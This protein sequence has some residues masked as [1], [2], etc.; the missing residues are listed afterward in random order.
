MFG[1]NAFYDYT[2]E[3]SHQR[4]GLGGEVFNQYGTF[5]VNG[6][7]GISDKRTLSDS[8]TEKAVNGWD[9]ALEAPIPKLPWVNINLKTSEFDR[10][11][12]K[13]LR[14]V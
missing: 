8:S 9:A 12:S 10:A 3:H 4:A 14:V 7:E 2:Q 13:F 11:A 6:Y 1:V 5:R